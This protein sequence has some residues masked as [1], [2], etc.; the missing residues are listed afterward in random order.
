[1]LCLCS[2][3]Q[4]SAPRIRG[5]NSYFAEPGRPRPGQL[6][7]PACPR[8]CRPGRGRRGPT[9][10]SAPNSW[11]AVLRIPG[12]DRGVV[13]QPSRLNRHPARTSV[14]PQ[15]YSSLATD[16]DLAELIQTLGDRSGRNGPTPATARPMTPADSGDSE[17]VSSGSAS[18]RDYTPQTN[19][20]RSYYN[21]PAAPASWRCCSCTRS[22]WRRRPRWH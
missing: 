11:G 4:Y 2:T 12:Q 7:G 21:T 19:S 15:H 18:Q 5:K 8:T 14:S 22:P 17:A 16:K 10:I 13:R 1:M 6:T 9:T 20:D 3:P